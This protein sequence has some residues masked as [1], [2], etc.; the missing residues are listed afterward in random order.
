MDVHERPHRLNS[1]KS[2]DFE[3]KGRKK[4]RMTIWFSKENYIFLKENYDGKISEIM[5]A[6]ATF[7]RTNNPITIQILKIGACG[8]R[9]LNPRTPTGRDPESRAFS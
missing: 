4:L 2:S 3:K 9:D 1:E 8:G 6:F 5:N 7:L